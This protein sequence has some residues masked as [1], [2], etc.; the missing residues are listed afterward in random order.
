MMLNY[1]RA[2]LGGNLVEGVA[3]VVG[4]RVSGVSLVGGVAW[5]MD[6][7]LNMWSETCLGGRFT[8][9]STLCV[10]KEEVKKGGRGGEGRPGDYICELWQQQLPHLSRLVL[11]ITFRTCLTERTFT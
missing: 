11:M 4:W 7:S 8:S 2:L 6:C 10:G 3:S 9:S 5:W 1:A